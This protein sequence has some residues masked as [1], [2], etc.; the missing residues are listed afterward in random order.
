MTDIRAAT[1]D[2]YVLRW[3]AGA[4]QALL[5]RRAEGTRCAG[6][7]EA[8][9]GRIEREER[10]EEAA[11]R[12]VREETGFSVERLYTTGVQPFYLPRASTITLAVVFAAVVSND[13]E[14][15]LSEE[16]SRAEWF[17]FEEAAARVAWPRSRVALGEI[18]AL[19]RGGDA[20]PVE[21]V[22]RVR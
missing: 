22:L 16:H 8:V 3:R 19:L 20:G 21:D 9:H 15:K 12:E 18:Q 2:A 11:V 1:V 14:M 7:W 10:P 4:W 17:D 6:A 5:L 13:S